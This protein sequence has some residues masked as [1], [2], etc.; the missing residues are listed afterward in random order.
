MYEGIFD[1]EHHWQIRCEIYGKTFGLNE[2][3][4]KSF[5]T[6]KEKEDGKA[7]WKTYF[8]HIKVSNHYYVVIVLMISGASILDHLC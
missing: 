4:H 1:D 8:R 3:V 5:A 6:F 7:T 2:D